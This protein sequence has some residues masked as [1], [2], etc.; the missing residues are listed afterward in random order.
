[1]TCVSTAIRSVGGRAVG[2]VEVVEWRTGEGGAGEGAS[3][4]GET[5]ES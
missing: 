4:A 5:R 3:G 1:M 2:V